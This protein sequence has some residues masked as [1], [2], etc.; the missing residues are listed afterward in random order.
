MRF[1]D[2]LRLLS[3]GAVKSTF[4]NVHVP[5]TV[6]F[7]C[8]NGPIKFLSTFSMSMSRIAEQASRVFSHSY[9]LVYTLLAFRRRAD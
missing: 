4:L 8:K 3:R 2:S 5:M 1:F 9:A 7:G 6:L